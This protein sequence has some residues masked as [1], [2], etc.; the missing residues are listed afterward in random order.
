MGQEKKNKNTQA[1]IINVRQIALS[2]CPLYKHQLYRFSLGSRSATF[3]PHNSPGSGCQAC[4]LLVGVGIG[5][6]AFLGTRL[7][8]H[9][10]VRGG[11]ANFEVGLGIGIHI[12][13]R[14]LGHFGTQFYPLSQEI[15]KRRVVEMGMEEMLLAL[16][17]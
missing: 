9:R 10:E 15:P 7:T 3:P 8:F 12:E 6:A 2:V 16:G 11:L 13:V 5:N 4:Y 17:L 1:P 14:S